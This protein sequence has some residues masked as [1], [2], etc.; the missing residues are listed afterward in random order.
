[1]GSVKSSAGILPGVVEHWHNGGTYAA[2][3]QVKVWYVTAAA[4]GAS[5]Y[6]DLTMPFSCSAN[7]TINVMV[8]PYSNSPYLSG[9][10]K[11]YGLTASSVRIG[12]TD[13]AGNWVNP[14]SWISAVVFCD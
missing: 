1:M 4:T 13:A 14:S 2:N 7:W 11:G 12:Y 8:M 5:G 3:P 9:I 10:P 6:V